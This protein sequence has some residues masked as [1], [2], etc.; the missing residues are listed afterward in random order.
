MQ[1]DAKNAQN[2]PIWQKK[3]LS[4]WR[5][6]RRA[7]K[8]S[9]RKQCAGGPRLVWFQLVQFPVNCD[10]KMTLNSA[11]PQY[12]AIYKHFTKAGNDYMYALIEPTQI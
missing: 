9:F 10:L 4:N 7:T 12:S 3:I 1:F 2:C 8:R 11:I 6:N 5:E